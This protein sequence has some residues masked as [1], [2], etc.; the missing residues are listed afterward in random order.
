MPKYRDVNTGE[1]LSQEQF[2]ALSD[3]SAPS[4]GGSTNQISFDSTGTPSTQERVAPKTRF[5]TSREVEPGS[6]NFLQRLRLGFGGKKAK[7]EQQRLEQEA[8]LKGS[9][10]VGD[11]A[12]VAGAALPFV[13]GLLGGAGGTIA[14]V[15]VGAVPG[16]AIGAASGESVRRAIGAGLGLREEEGDSYPVRAKEALNLVGDVVKQGAFYYIGGKAV[17]AAAKLPGIKQ[18]IKLAT[19]KIP[20]R[21]YST[22]FKTTADDLAEQIKT[23][24]IQ[25]LQSTNPELFKTFVKEGLVKVGK[26]GKVE[27][28]PTL[29]KQALQKG[30]GGSLEKMAEF[31]YLKQ[32]ESE[33]AAR[34]AVRG[35]KALIDI[36]KDKV[37]Y[38]KMLKDTYQAF[39]K[40]G[41]GF[42]KGA[43]QEAKNIEAELAKAKGGKISAELA[44]R[45]RRVIDGLRQS[46]SFRSSAVLGP[47]QA[48]FKAAADKLRGKLASDV[49]GLA[50]IMKDYKFYIDSADSLVGEAA[51][52]GNNR[53]FSLF[54]AVVGGS[55]ISALGGP[56][57]VGVFAALRTI[58]SPA[59]LT[60]LARQLQAT[61]RRVLRGAIPVAGSLVEPTAKRLFDRSA[62]K[63]ETPEF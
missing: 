44:L 39:G 41:Y 59:I 11:I 49:P 55:S 22:F 61:P 23:G 60:F 36:G 24:G 12:D 45:L 54:D 56:G 16:A 32:L 29:A 5:G 3:S 30:L 42:L 1:I 50:K 14:G 21:I 51:R 57:G 13:G 19:E 52:R 6:V 18:G 4:L 63:E 34:N 2:D 33:V 37:G 17:Q 43:A 8:G 58:Q 15:G 25:K 47:K 7:E 26:A 10:D 48:I 31:S 38:A 28:D 53:I 46:G 40:E 27:I 9:F 35:T 62:P 20:E